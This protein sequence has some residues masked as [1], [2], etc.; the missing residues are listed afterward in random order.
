MHER[1]NNRVSLFLRSKPVTGI[2]L[3]ALGVTLLKLGLPENW[4]DLA[5][6]TVAALAT[7]P[8]GTTPTRPPARKPR[9]KNRTTK[10]RNPRNR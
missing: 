6:L 10:R 1:P 8:A 4:I 9:R 5:A 3:M 7:Q 2:I